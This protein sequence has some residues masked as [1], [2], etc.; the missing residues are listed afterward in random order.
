MLLSCTCQSEELVGGQVVGLC[1][2][3]CSVHCGV[4]V[5]GIVVVIVGPCVKVVIL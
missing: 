4:V 1:D 5:F 3:S 2:V